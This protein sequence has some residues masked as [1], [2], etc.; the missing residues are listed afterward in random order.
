MSTEAQSKLLVSLSIVQVVLATS[1]L[2][3]PVMY[4]MYPEQE[5]LLLGSLIIF[6]ALNMLA[7]LSNR[8]KGENR[9]GLFFSIAG[10]VILATGASLLLF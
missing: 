6:G 1:I 5:S 4:L 8:I 2:F 3:L 10:V 7:G 9:S